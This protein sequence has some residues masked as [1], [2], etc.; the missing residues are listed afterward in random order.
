MHRGWKCPAPTE[1]LHVGPGDALKG[2]S[3][4][5]GGGANAFFVLCRVGKMLKPVKVCLKCLVFNA[6]G[7]V[8]CRPQSAAGRWAR[9]RVERRIA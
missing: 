2:T 4:G 3:P 8:V 1:L 7:A 9:W 6:L 5:L